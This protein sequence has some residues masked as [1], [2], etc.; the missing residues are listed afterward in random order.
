MTIE[1]LFAGISVRRNGDASCMVYRKIRP[2]TIVGEKEGS[3][4]EVLG[5]IIEFPKRLEGAHFVAP[6]PYAGQII[7]ELVM[8][9]IPVDVTNSGIALTVQ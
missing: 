5:Y 7:K 4:K 1:N 8:H 9:N 3:L 6:E 2:Y